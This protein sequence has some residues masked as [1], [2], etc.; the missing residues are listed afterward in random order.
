[1]SALEELNVTVQMLESDV[2]SLRQNDTELMED[3]ETLAGN[4]G[5]LNAS[6]EDVEQRIQILEQ[7]ETIAFHACLATYSSIPEN[8]VVVFPNI[9]ENLGNGYNGATGEFTVPPGGAGV[10]YFYA[11][12]LSAPGGE[13]VSM[14][15]RHNG[16]QKCIA[17]TSDST[18]YSNYSCGAVIVLKEG[19]YTFQEIFKC[20]NN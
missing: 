9:E 19:R 17:F 15:L 3:L 13:W 7:E 8:T 12:F 18:W 6:I 4:V 16:D 10:Y 20:S 5:S 1:M 2:K 14:W 11:H